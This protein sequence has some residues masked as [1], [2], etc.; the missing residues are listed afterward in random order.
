MAL[1][2][3]MKYVDE[4]DKWDYFSKWYYSHE[5]WKNLT[6][7]NFCGYG[8]W[9]SMNGNAVLFGVADNVEDI[10]DSSNSPVVIPSNGVTALKNIANLC[11]QNGIKLIVTSSYAYEIY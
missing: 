8:T 10:Y 4:L 5:N 2:E 7:Y 3:T 1:K 11:E 9:K 6:E